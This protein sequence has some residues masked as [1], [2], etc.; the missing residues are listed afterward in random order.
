MGQIIKR[1]ELHKIIKELKSQNKKIVTTNGAFD[2]IHEGHIKS[3]KF[4]KKHGD[5]LIVGLN[6]DSSINEYKSKN[7]PVKNQDERALI[8]SSIIYVDYVV[9]FEEKTPIAL[10][11]E[12]KPN[13]HIKGSEYIENLPERE[14]VEKNGGKI[15]FLERS[16]N[17]NS[18]SKIID[19]I[20]KSYGDTS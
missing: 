15:V 3:L 17:E 7:R 1:D 11:E 13:I 16:E 6:T 2:L 20:K 9:L 18:T 12:I 8:L 5:I 4:A 19:K 14:I 10:L